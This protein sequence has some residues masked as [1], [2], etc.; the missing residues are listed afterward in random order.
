MR[1]ENLY[2]GIKIVGFIT[3]IP[4]ILAAGPL[5]GF[6]VGDF[7]EKKFN[8]PTYVV[9]IGIGVGFLVAVME[10]LKIL[11]AVAKA[12]KNEHG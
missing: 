5:A 11:K 1:K 10:L 12:I 9:F 6:W 7:L 3:F 8:F 4:F 2:Q